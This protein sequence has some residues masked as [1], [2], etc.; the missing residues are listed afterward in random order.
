MRG[1]GSDVRDDPECQVR[2]ALSLDF[3]GDDAAEEA[4]CFLEGL[5]EDGQGGW[6]GTRGADENQEI[7]GSRVQGLHGFDGKVLGARHQWRWRGRIRERDGRLCSIGAR[8][9]LRV[10]GL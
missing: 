1:L 6:V 2:G 7:A 5:F 9:L 10:D 4:G 3:R 8:G